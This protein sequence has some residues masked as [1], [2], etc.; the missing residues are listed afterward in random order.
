MNNAK[1]RHLVY[2]TSEIYI[3][4]SMDAFLLYR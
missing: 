3:M 4:L 2:Y 1:L